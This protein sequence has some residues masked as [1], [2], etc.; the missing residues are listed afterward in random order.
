VGEPGCIWPTTDRLLPEQLLSEIAAGAS[1]ADRSGRLS[2][3]T[4]DSLRRAGY[5][6]LPVPETL[7]GHGA[8][9][10]TCAAVQRRLAMADPA[11]AVA[12]NMHLYSVG[13][14]AEH[15]DRRRDACGLL[16]EAIA[17]Q[18]R[19]VASAFAEPGLG[20]SLV[21]STMT[22]RRTA[23]GYLVSGVKSPC[24]LAAHCDLV[25]FQ[26]QVE[27]AE[28][29]GVLTVIIP[30]QTP[31]LRVEPTWNSL[32][33]RGSGSETLKFDQC[34]VPNE[35]IFQRA[36]PGAN[37]DEVFAAG[38]VW[39]CVTTTAIY[40]GLATAAVEAACEGLRQAWL[41]YLGST[42]ADLATV[43][44]RLGELVAG[45]LTLDAA[46]AGIADR[47]DKRLV[48]ARS[49]VPLAVAVKHDSVEK[50][51]AAVEGAAE[52]VG[53][54][55]YAHAG[56][57]ARLW[58]DVQAAR[59]HPPTRLVAPQFLGRWTLGVRSAPELPEGQSA[60]SLDARPD[61]VGPGSRS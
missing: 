31:G 56:L 16:L 7:H 8:G 18:Q 38:L 55:A 48:D 33:M 61:V 9:L 3:S 4:L 5:F 15:W 50:C 39:F 2:S 6:G 44:A 58:R 28:P 47:L 45:T 40:L 46:C 24:S 43:Q 1:D 36:D 27:P 20:G 21:R 14:W 51:I 17:T 19:I 30:A 41:P 25:C 13:I 26:M 59:F 22:A 32:G 37:D 23:G 10:L 57:L 42:R 60:A 54:R 52:L 53:S 29:G 34:F 35:L 12:L 11:L 49:L